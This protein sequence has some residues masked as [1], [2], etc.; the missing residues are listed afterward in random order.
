MT[1]DG[2]LQVEF[3]GEVRHV[4]A[5][6]EL[7]FGRAADMVIDDNPH[8][9]RVLGRFWSRGGVWW[10]TNEGRTITVSVADSNSRSSV[11]LAPGSDIALSFA[12][13][14]LR[15]RAGVTEYEVS[16]HLPDRTNV[17]HDEVDDD[18]DLFADDL[19]ERTIGHGMIPL[20]PEQRLLLLALAEGTLRDPHGNPE[21]PANRAVAKRLGWPLTKFNRKLDNLCNRFT[22]LGVSGLKGSIDQLASDRRRR[23]VDHAIEIGLIT[24]A[25]L[26]SLPAGPDGG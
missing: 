18:D 6:E 7:T 23:L 5:G 22:R 8:L 12:S 1:D 11:T 21:L 2:Q 4:N 13:A 9:H 19:D 3:C 10:L 26:G 24:A 14:T 16:A 20:A 15:F 25:D 17:E